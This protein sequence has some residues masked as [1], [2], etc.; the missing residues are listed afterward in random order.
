MT[1]LIAFAKGCAP[2]AEPVCPPDDVLDGVDVSRWQ[3]DIDWARVPVDFAIARVSDGDRVPD[4]QFDRNWAGMADQGLVRGAYQL[5]RASQDPDAQA[6]RM[7]A[8]IADLGDDDLPPVL[9]LELDDGVGRDE[10]VAGARR[11]LDRVEA[12]SGRTPM[13]YTS[14]SFWARL[15]DTDGF[16]RYPLWIAHWRVECPTVPAPW[17]SWA[18]WQTTDDGRVDGIAGPVDLDVRAP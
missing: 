17:T 16:E 8:A 4:A 10:V 18:I 5:F 9:D 6:D 15:P 14:P 12:G 3:G 11:W 1:A 13:I 7:L 2:A